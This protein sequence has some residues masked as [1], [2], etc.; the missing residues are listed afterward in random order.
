MC[1]G[2]EEGTFKDT[3]VHSDAS[4]TEV[5]KATLSCL[6]LLLS[7]LHSSGLLKFIK[8]KKKGWNRWI[9]RNIASKTGILYLV[10]QILEYTSR[11]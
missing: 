10:L 8:K 3:S 7:C 9:F 2:G 5:C 11:E 1:C 4:V 6:I